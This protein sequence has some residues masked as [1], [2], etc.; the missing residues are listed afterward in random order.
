MEQEIHHSEIVEMMEFLQKF[1]NDGGKI[2]IADTEYQFLHSVKEKLHDIDK[3]LSQEEKRILYS[4]IKNHQ[5]HIL[6]LDWIDTQ[7]IQWKI[8]HLSRTII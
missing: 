3:T 8:Q 1:F 5:T 6:Q 7:T 4:T 2:E